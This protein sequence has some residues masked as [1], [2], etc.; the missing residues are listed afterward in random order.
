MITGLATAVESEIASNLI[1]SFIQ[2]AVG[3]GILIFFAVCWYLIGRKAGVSHAWFAFIPLLNL[4]VPWK[5]SRT[6]VWTIVA[7]LII[8]PL[9]PVLLVVILADVFSRF[10]GEP[11][12]SVSVLVAAAALLVVIVI[13]DVIIKTWWH[14]RTATRLG[15]SAWVGALA[16]PLARLIPGG[17]LVR[18]LF[19]GFLAFRS[20]PF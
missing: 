11:F 20:E 15:Y 16:S 10:G 18:G 13:L 17:Q 5:A 7:S 12:L 14:V 2:L 4:F 6:P 1:A 9:A 8:A 19:L 3:A